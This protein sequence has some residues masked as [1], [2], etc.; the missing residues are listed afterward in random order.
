MLFLNVHRDGD[1]SN[2]GSLVKL[3]LSDNKIETIELFAFRVRNI[4]DVETLVLSW[5]AIF[6]LL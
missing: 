4:I 5:L 1:F 2:L 6:L 3:D